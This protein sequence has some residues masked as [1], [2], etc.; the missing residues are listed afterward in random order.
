MNIREDVLVEELLSDVAFLDEFNGNID[1]NYGSTEDD[2]DTGESVND[3]NLNE[4]RRKEEEEERKRKARVAAR[5]KAAREKRKRERE[6]LEEK[7]RALEMENERHKRTVADLQNEAQ[8]L[9]D[10]GQVDLKLE[11]NLLRAEIMEYRK[12]VQMF[13][14]FKAEVPDEKT[15]D[16]K[17]LRLL[18]QGIS[19][20]INSITSFLSIST[21]D[22]T[23]QWTK[24]NASDPEA[25]DSMIAKYQLLPIG[26][27]FKNA[28]IL[29]VRVDYKPFDF[30]QPFDKVCDALFLMHSGGDGDSMTEA[31]GDQFKK[32]REELY[33]CEFDVKYDLLSLDK[34]ARDGQIVADDDGLTPYDKVRS[35]KFEHFYK[36][37][38]EKGNITEE[39]TNDALAITAYRNKHP[40]S[41]TFFPF[42]KDDNNNNNDNIAPK[43]VDTHIISTITSSSMKQLEDLPTLQ[44][45]GALGLKAGFF[46]EMENGEIIG[47]RIASIPLIEDDEIGFIGNRVSDLKKYFA[48]ETE[49][50]KEHS[51]ML[52]VTHEV[53]FQ[54]DIEED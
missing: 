15:K 35:L 47:T 7:I 1:D 13:K 37:K 39:I 43:Q 48:S 6:V 28:K 42:L 51:E 3:D 54:S 34:I 18:N 11:N 32:S 33:N 53:L 25:N 20:A 30:K 49:L 16:L 12:F 40:L 31:F 22:S 4:K 10:I 26:S 23:W 14:R 2:Y 29:N 44:S 8:K 50:S 24:M 45:V 19:S 46:T 38:D 36:L 41:N 27:T 17:R 9:R 21:F 52:V 5:S